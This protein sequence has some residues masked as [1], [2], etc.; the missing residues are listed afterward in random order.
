MSI[1]GSHPSSSRGSADRECTS[2]SSKVLLTSTTASNHTADEMDESLLWRWS[3]ETCM[4]LTDIQKS[5]A[6]CADRFLHILYICIGKG[7]QRWLRSACMSQCHNSI[8]YDPFL[9]SHRRDKWKQE[10]LWRP[11]NCLSEPFFFCHVHSSAMLKQW[12]SIPGDW[13]LWSGRWSATEMAIDNWCIWHVPSNFLVMYRTIIIT[14]GEKFT[15]S[16]WKH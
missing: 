2:F 6:R 10:L 16:G 8:R 14:A 5:P 3:Q 1:N 12:K 4:F 15:A 9:L 11:R 7:K 13:L